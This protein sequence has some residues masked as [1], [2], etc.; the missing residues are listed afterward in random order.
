M[1]NSP[2]VNRLD[3]LKSAAAT[4]AAA[5]AASAVCFG[6]QKS[7]HRSRTSPRS[8]TFSSPTSAGSLTYFKVRHNGY[9][10]ALAIPLGERS[11]PNRLPVRGIDPTHMDDC[12]R[13]G[14]EIVALRIKGKGA[15]SRMCLFPG[16]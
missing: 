9:G 7:S 10:S 6:L 14:E 13:V 11:F 2:S 5:D 15:S 4:R 8:A 16:A 3:F 1:S 12:Q